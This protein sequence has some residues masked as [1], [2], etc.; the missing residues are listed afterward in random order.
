MEAAERQSKPRTS[1]W[2]IAARWIF[3]AIAVYGVIGLFI[4]PPL[5]RKLIVDNLSDRLGRKVTLDEVSANPYTL[6]ARVHGLKVYERDGRAVF[7]S[8][9][10]FRVAVS[11]ASLYRW[12]PVVNRI[13]VAG[14]DVHLVRDSDNRYNVS[15]ILERL[16]QSPAQTGPGPHEKA[17]FALSNIRLAQADVDFD[18][19]PR[20]VHHRVTDI[21][22]T[23]PS[24]STLGNDAREAVKPTLSMRVN[25]A[26]FSIQGESLPFEKDLRTRLALGFDDVK[27]PE[28][29][30]YSPT[31]L[32]VRIGAGK[33]H[34][35]LV[36][37][38]NRAATGD[39]AIDLGGT[40]GVEGLE[41]SGPQ[42]EGDVVVGS[43]EVE[44]ASLDPLGGKAIV[45]LVRLSDVSARG[46]DWRLG[47]AQAREI[48]ADLHGRSVNVGELVTRGAQLA[49]QRDA[50]GH[51]AGLQSVSATSASQAPPSKPWEVTIAKVNADDWHL[52]LKD[53]AVHPAVIHRV[54]LEHLAATNLSNAD[55]AKA[56]IEGRLALASGGRVD[57]RSSIALQP[58]AVEATIDGRGIDLAPLK[59]YAAHFATVEL[60]GAKASVKGTV[61]VAGS[62]DAMRIAY[63]GGAELADVATFD[64]VNHEELLDW[65]SVR[66]KGIDF[67]WARHDPLRLAVDEVAVDKAYARVVVT[68]DGRLNLQTL[69]FAT[70]DNPAPAPQDPATLKPRD[71]NI[72]RIV[73]EGSRLDFADHFIKPNYS[74]DIGD[75]G[76]SVTGLSSDP[77]AR[78]QVKL[79]GSYDGKSPIVIGGT[80]NPLSGELFADIAA[81][82]SNIALPQFSAYSARYAGY[83]IT[84]GTLALDVDYHVENGKLQARNGIV[85]DQLTFGD[86]VA[87]PEAT[88]LP[89]LFAVNLLKDSQGRIKV[90]L[91]ISGSLD[92]PQFDMGKVVAQVVGNLLKKAVT[93]PFSLLSAALGG[94]SQAKA[95]GNA[96]PDLEHVDFAAGDAKL[97]EED[98]RKL[99]QLSEALAQHPAVKVE[100]EPRIDAQKDGAALQAAG[101]K[102]DD[103]SLKALAASRAEAVRQALEQKLPADRVIVA[104]SSAAGSPGVGFSLR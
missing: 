3:G 72:H 93:S 43:A 60:K 40:V 14:L 102:A 53:E 28:Y 34:A 104:D 73:F 47:L 103:A 88:K 19:R 38:F 71:V 18:D 36:I 96:A 68:P 26:P 67:H 56:E 9:S 22:L 84:G 48:T 63:K 10:D 16:A 57:V 12:A 58:F 79:T 52:A 15:D 51:L 41:L 89:V 87:S 69:K 81:K 86:R 75:L 44:V 5:A 61:K 1:R 31:K 7:A 50:H 8:L 95:A 65:K 2:R 91:P 99:A 23:I 6:R 94:S 64:T 62:G 35:K 76:G 45:P 90:D 24:I 66:A 83:G 85:L 97:D 25:G 49:L 82:G 80:V 78:A 30:S 101:L 92:D 29:V 74:A 21:N 17:R 33:L 13:G 54:A 98:R 59:P 100:L 77:R 70:A 11:P 39:P 20:G 55:G 32:P 27:I 37:R 46:G 4:A 42:P